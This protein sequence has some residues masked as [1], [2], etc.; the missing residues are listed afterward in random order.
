MPHWQLNDVKQDVIDS[1]MCEKTLAETRTRPNITPR[2]PK[3]MLT[4]VGRAGVYKNERLFRTAHNPHLNAINIGLWGC[5]GGSD[6][7][8]ACGASVYFAHT[9]L[10]IFAKGQMLSATV[11]S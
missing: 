7:G 1:G 4:S 6:D 5:G 8:T 2:S 10:K 3:T 11:R 9:G